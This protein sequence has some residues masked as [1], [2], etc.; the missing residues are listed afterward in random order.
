MGLAV[1][2]RRRKTRSLHGRRGRNQVCTQTQKSFIH[3]CSYD[4]VNRGG[5]ITFVWH[6]RHQVLKRWNLMQFCLSFPEQ[7]DTQYLK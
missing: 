7:V 6:L 3:I 5:L 4:G 1:R 2:D